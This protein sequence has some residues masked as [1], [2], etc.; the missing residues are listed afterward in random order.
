M[1][2]VGTRITPRPPHNPGGGKPLCSAAALISN[3]RRRA[4]LTSNA[5]AA[6][7][8]LG[9]L[10]LLLC[11]LLL[12]G[13]LD[14]LALNLPFKLRRIALA[15]AVALT[16]IFKFQGSAALGQSPARQ[17][18]NHNLWKENHA[19]FGHPVP[20]NKLIHPWNTI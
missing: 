5:P 7:R 13:F 3:G 12:N 16:A 2:A 9:L 4:A 18:L 15:G 11:R 1:V 6:P 10:L 20:L 8:A 14:R 17:I 19:I